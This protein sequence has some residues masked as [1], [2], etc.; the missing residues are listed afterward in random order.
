MVSKGK[1]K[2]YSL[3]DMDMIGICVDDLV[4]DDN[5]VRFVDGDSGYFTTDEIYA[6]FQN[7]KSILKKI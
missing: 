4:K 6:I 7:L 5:E 2:D 1:F 3:W